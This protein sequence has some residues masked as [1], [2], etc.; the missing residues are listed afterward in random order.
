MNEIY[1][2]GNFTTEVCGENNCV[3]ENPD[4]ANYGNFILDEN[5]DGRCCISDECTYSNGTDCVGR[6]QVG[7]GCYVNSGCF[8]MGACHYEDTCITEVN[9]EI[10]DF[11]QGTFVTRGTCKNF[12]VFGACYG[13]DKGNYSCNYF[14][15]PECDYRLGQFV[16]NET[17]PV[18]QGSCCNSEGYCSNVP[19]INCELDEVYHVN[20]TCEEVDCAATNRIESCCISPF[21]SPFVFTL[22]ELECEFI[23]SIIGDNI[24][25][26]PYIPEQV[27][28]STGLCFEEGINSI[29][30]EDYEMTNTNY[31]D[32]STLRNVQVKFIKSNFI[33]DNL[34]VSE[35]SI[36]SLNN[37]AM[38]INHGSF[39]N[40][41]LNFDHKSKISAI[42]CMDIDQ[43]QINLD[44]QD[45]NVNVTLFQFEEIC[46]GKTLNF[47]YT[48]TVKGIPRD[49]LIV[50][51]DSSSIFMANLCG[52]ENT[53]DNT[54]NR[55]DYIFIPIIIASLFGALFL[56]LAIGFIV[57][58]QLTKD[59]ESIMG[60]LQI[61]GQQP[62]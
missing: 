15:E 57:K 42:G 14:S 24:Y 51:Y 49:C 11:I 47:N 44:V 46:I 53:N 62:K 26:M 45:D 9:E 54:D 34:T 2:E 7:E 23:E 60:N 13:S 59:N 35:K 41:I 8:P 18:Y 6:Y 21:C 39:Q 25:Y 27:C 20:K 55:Q 22:T 61:P 1:C 12:L 58:R 3:Y 5:S 43:T 32:S 31:S 30:V 50:T 33:I 36:F 17:C 16:A 29:V 19:S 48:V 38:I 28:P 37:T 56:A 4:F 40:V 10:C 52:E